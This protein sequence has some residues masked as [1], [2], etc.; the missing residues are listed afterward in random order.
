MTGLPGLSVERLAAG[1]R[2]GKALAHKRD[3]DAVIGGLG[4]V[5]EPADVLVGDDCAAIPDGRGG[6]L[7]L[8]IEGFVPSFVAAEP[9]FAGYCG[10]MVNL[11]DVAAMGGRPIAVVD[12]LWSRGDERAVP[13]LE[14]L[15]AASAA[16]G[17]PIVGGHSNSRSDS[18]QLAV[19]VLGRAT[20]LLTSF[21]ARPGQVLLA[22]L[23]LRGRYHDPHPYWDASTGSPAARLRGDLELLPTLAEAGLASVAKDISMAGLVGTALM[24]MEASGVGGV[25]DVR[26][27]PRPE[28][29]PLDRWLASFPSYGF[30]LAVDDAQVGPVQERFAARD[31]ACAAIGRLDASRRLRLADGDDE[32]TVWDL[33]ASPLTG[34]APPARRA[35]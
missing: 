18:D 13:I 33:A 20:R 12:A 34:C 27:V 4:L 28:A 21:D 35:A 32:A 24:L 16:Y 15:R 19:A 26:A 7:L 5:G 2:D 6:W 22:A 8:A 17:V 1:I 3:I 31:L 29:V 23:D 25:I 30:L 11:A 10:L 9:R 14:G